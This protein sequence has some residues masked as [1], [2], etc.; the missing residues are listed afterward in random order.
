MKKKQLVKSDKPKENAAKALCGTFGG[1]SC[2]INGST[3]SESDILL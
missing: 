2:T 1:Q 3:G